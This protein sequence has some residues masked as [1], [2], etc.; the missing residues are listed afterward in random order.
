MTSSGCRNSAAIRLFWRKASRSPP[1]PQRK[2]LLC[3]SKERD[4]IV[5]SKLSNAV[6][7]VWELGVFLDLC[8]QYNIRLI[9]IND[10]IDSRGELFPETTVKDVLKTIGA[11]SFETTK[12]GRAKQRVTEKKIGVKPKTPKVGLRIDQEKTVVNMYNSDYC[13][14][15]IWQA[16]RYKS[17][18]SVFRVLN[19]NGV[20]VNRGPHLGPIKKK[21]SDIHN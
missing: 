15:D 7:G 16:S 2:K 9:S 14:D 18:T 1:R 20:Q 21:I 8:S 11:I 12:Y 17:R 5:V 3:E 4:T 13:I 10:N 19:R 6:R